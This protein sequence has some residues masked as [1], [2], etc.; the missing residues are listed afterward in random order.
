M[1]NERYARGHNWELLRQYSDAQGLCFE[2]LKMSDGEPRLAMVWAAPVEK[3]R[4]Q[5]RQFESRFL[6]LKNPWTDPRVANW[7]GYCAGSCIGPNAETVKEFDGD[8]GKT[9]I[10]LAIYGL[11]HPKVPILLVDFRDKYNPKTRE[12]SRRVIADVVENLFAF[13]KIGNIPLLAGSMLFNFWTGRT[14]MD[15]NQPPRFD[16]YSDLKL[17]LAL[18]ET[19]DPALKKEITDRIEYVSLNPLENDLDVEIKNSKRQYENLVAYAKR[20]ERTSGNR[21]K[22]IARRGIGSAETWFREEDLVRFGT[23]LFVRSV[24]SPRKDDSRICNGP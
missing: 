5:N 3:E 16:A 6:N 20:P 8:Y 22:R 11:D 9:L 4:F 23:L 19:L 21:C 1:A 17:F 12:M 10:P 2:P 7:K 24:Y 14:G 18:D 15:W 13:S